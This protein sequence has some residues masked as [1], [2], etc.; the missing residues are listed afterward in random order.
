MGVYG[1]GNRRRITPYGKWSETSRVYLDLHRFKSSLYIVT[2]A[3][4]EDVKSGE[5]GPEVIMGFS[6]DGE[7]M[8][9][10]LTSLTHRELQALKEFM[11]IAVANAQDIVIRRDEAAQE[12]LENG[13][14]SFVRIYRRIPE[15][16]IR[17]GE[18]WRDYPR[19]RRGFEWITELVPDFATKVHNIRG[20][21]SRVSEP[22]KEDP[23]TED[24]EQEARNVS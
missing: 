12:A 16:V 21:G 6:R 11:N 1:R 19:V 13:D 2:G 15:I 20:A 17:E 9:M 7:L 18:K 8:Y 22:V 23:S 14:D 5:E 24:G 4:K 10:N 3:N